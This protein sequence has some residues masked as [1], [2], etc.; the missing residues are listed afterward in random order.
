MTMRAAR[1]GG[2]DV[3]RGEHAGAAGAE[4]EDV[5]GEVVDGEHRE[6]SSENDKSTNA[7]DRMSEGAGT[8]DLDT[9]RFRHSTHF[10]QDAGSDEGVDAPPGDGDADGEE[11]D[12]D[13][14]AEARA[15]GVVEA[16]VADAVEAVVE[17]DEQERD[18]DGDE[19]GV[20]EEA[21]LDDFER[22]AVGGAHF[23]REV[24]DPEV[25]DEQHEQAPSVLPVMR[26]RV[27]VDG[28]SGHEITKFD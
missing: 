5:A 12:G 17:G 22:E 23:G 21:A 7:N 26:C 14:S 2:G 10:L 25:H 20:L 1:V 24:L 16:D 11:D 9:P 19:P 28:A 4:D 27:P 13:W 8:S 18:V 3:E 15:P 6:A